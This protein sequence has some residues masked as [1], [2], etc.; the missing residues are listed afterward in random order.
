MSEVCPGHALD[1]RILDNTRRTFRQLDGGDFLETAREVALT[2]APLQENPFSVFGSESP[3]S[4]M[5]ARLVDAGNWAGAD[6]LYMDWIKT[7]Y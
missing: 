5:Y 6:K 4:R 2:A 7:R 3:E 1:R